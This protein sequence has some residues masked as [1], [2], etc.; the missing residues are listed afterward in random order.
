MGGSRSLMH[1]TSKNTSSMNPTQTE[2]DVRNINKLE[3]VLR[4]QR[5]RLEN[6]SGAF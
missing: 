2:D 5:E 3:D 6:I 4:R 1:Q